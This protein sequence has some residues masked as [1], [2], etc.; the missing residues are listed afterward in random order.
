[1]DRG[2]TRYFPNMKRLLI[3]LSLMLCAAGCGV[4]GTTVSDATQ[5]GRESA[6]AAP[7]SDSDALRVTE[8]VPAIEPMEPGTYLVSTLTFPA[9]E[10]LSPPFY[11]S[12]YSSGLP[13][14][15]DS[16][17]FYLAFASLAHS[18]SA[19]DVAD[20]TYIHALATD[21]CS[22]CRSHEQ[23][24]ADLVSQNL[25]V[26]GWEFTD[27]AT[28]SFE[29][30]ETGTGSIVCRLPLLASASQVWDAAGNLVFEEPAREDW[31]NLEMVY[32]DGLWRVNGLSIEPIA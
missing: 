4:D 28:H 18:S 24:V 2:E 10:D 15:T 11:E 32:V 7:L 3:A 17:Y 20:L 12:M 31:Y 13:G 14:A 30:Y 22:W 9:I 6:A 29:S 1:M 26:T 16:A 8:E 23:L 19:D 27:S 5:P 21:E 25:R